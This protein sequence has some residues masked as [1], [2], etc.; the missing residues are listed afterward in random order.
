MKDSTTVEKVWRI[1]DAFR[2]EGCM[3]ITQLAERTSLLPSDVHRL[4]KS[5]EHFGF[6]EQEAETRKYYLGLELLKLGH[7]VHQRLEIRKIAEPYLRQLAQ[8]AEATANLAVFDAR[9]L[10]VIFIEQVD[11]PNEFRVRLRIGAPVYPHATGVGKVL[12]A[13]MDRE[14]AR[15]VFGKRGL[16]KRTSHTITNMAKL[17]KELDRVLAQGYAL[18]REEGLKGAFCIAAPVLDHSGAVAAAVSISMLASGISGPLESRL[19]TAVLTNAARISA[20]LGYHANGA[21]PT[22]A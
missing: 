22:G 17:E 3:G 12:T 15:R 9:E 14:L 8:Q 11:S 10:E 18:D 2:G 5:L 13:H 19:I 16:V 20:D 4:I 21:E 6:I 7:L 1:F